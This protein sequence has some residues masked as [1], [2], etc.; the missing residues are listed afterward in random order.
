MISTSTHTITGGV[1][2]IQ[3]F[4]IH[5]GPG[6]RTTVFLKGCPLRCLWCHNPEGISNRNHLSFDPAKCIG[7]GSC[8]RAC[9]NGAH[10]NDGQEAHIVKRDRCGV[11]GLCTVACYA[12]AL[13]IVG[14]EM[15]VSEVMDE[16]SRDI[17]FYESSGGGLTLSGGEPLLQVDFVESLL[18]CA[19]TKGIHCALETCGE[20][21]F[22][23]FARVIRYVDLFLYDIKET[24]EERHREYTG[25]S[26]IRIL[27]NLKKL[28]D[29]NA[30]ILVRLPII[31]GLNDRPGHFENLASLA[32]ELPNILGMEVMPYHRLGTGKSARMGIDAGAALEVEPPAQETVARW[33]LSLRELGVPVV[34]EV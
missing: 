27:E 26:N 17:P 18:R 11:C 21:D 3:R 1:F 34:N 13:E 6:I 28:H 15:S 16:V 10:L 8:F 7:C 32:D 4:S 25:R 19:K 12:G 5:D 14:R 31:P 2:D 24:D 33:V 20:G 30:S 9:P 29:A 22:S 23:R